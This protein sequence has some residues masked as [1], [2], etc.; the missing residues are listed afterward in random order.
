MPLNSTNKWCFDIVLLHKPWEVS[1]I[2]STLLLWYQMTS[3][4]AREGATNRIR[5]NINLC[6]WNRLRITSI[7]SYIIYSKLNSYFPPIQLHTNKQMVANCI[8][9]HE[10][11]FWFCF[12]SSA[13]NH[14]PYTRR[15]QEASDNFT[16]NWHIIT[17]SLFILRISVCLIIIQVWLQWDCTSN[18]NTRNTEQDSW[19]CYSYIYILLP[20][21]KI[22][23][24]S[25]KMYWNINTLLSYCFNTWISITS[26]LFIS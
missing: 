22:L 8:W 2:P 9:N 24:S 15:Q 21:I 18:F 7:W 13:S 12:Q 6:Y 3:K 1:R 25:K 11:W 19:F 16:I 26:W 17:D 4:K 5:L 10:K 14:S 23:S 20:K